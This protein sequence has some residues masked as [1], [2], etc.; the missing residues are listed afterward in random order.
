MKTLFVFLAIAFWQDDFLTSERSA[1]EREYKKKLFALSKDDA[2]ECYKL[3]KWCWEHRLGQEYESLL[4]E[5]IKIDPDHEEARKEQG[6]VKPNG[7]WVKLHDTRDY[8]IA[9][10]KIKINVDVDVEKTYKKNKQFESIKNLF[11]DAEFW[12]PLLRRIDES[13]G[14]YSKD[15]IDIEVIFQSKLD[16]EHSFAGA[17]GGGGKIKINSPTIINTSKMQIASLL[18]HE[19]VHNYQT[20]LLLKVVKRDKSPDDKESVDLSWLVEG[21]A[22]Y[23]AN[24]DFTLSFLKRTKLEELGLKL[25]DYK[26]SYGRG[27]L[28]FKYL[29]KHYGKKGV[30]MVCQLICDDSIHP[31]QAIEKVTRRQWETFKKDELQW[32]SKYFLSNIA[33]GLAATS[34]DDILKLLNSKN[35]W[36]RILAI[37]VLANLGEKEHAKKIAELLTDKDSMIA[38]EAALALASL[39]SKEFASD[40]TKLLKSKDNV[41]KSTAAVS[42]GLLGAKQYTKDVAELLDVKEIKTNIIWSLGLLEAKD[43]AKDIV[44]LLKDSNTQLRG[45]TLWALGKM[46]AKDCAKEIS[47]LTTDN[48]FWNMYDPFTYQFKTT[49][50]A[51]TAKEVLLAWGIKPD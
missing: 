27:L 16:T 41:T 38:C 24:E 9:A 4:K 2:K 49:T 18:Q 45:F 12:A 40:I 10:K 50:I 36:E 39:G 14:L 37:R 44:H 17:I 32:S 5:I 43:Y 21:M 47:K 8:R 19:M 51:Q 22:S 25:A 33:E 35:Y 20:N 42:L 3:A 11:G 28:F 30:K 31:Q 26:H 48:A 29:E 1:Y 13:I 7:K 23:V 46:K 15:G 34:V 6:Y